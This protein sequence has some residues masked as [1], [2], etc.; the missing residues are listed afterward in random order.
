LA[1]QSVMQGYS[2]IL[3]ILV[4]L[5]SRISLDQRLGMPRRIAGSYDPFKIFR[6]ATSP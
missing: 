5:I 4:I 3:V 1:D 2:V 6:I